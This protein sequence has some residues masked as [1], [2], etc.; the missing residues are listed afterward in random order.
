MLIIAILIILSVLFI[1]KLFLQFRYE[2]SYFGLY[3]V[4]LL[5][6]RN[7]KIAKTSKDVQRALCLRDK[8]VAIEELIAA[9]AW[10]P[11]LSIESV[12][13][14]KWIQLKAN[15]AIFHKHLPTVSELGSKAR[16]EIKTFLN[17]NKGTVLDSKMISLMTLKIFLKWLF[18]DS[19]LLEVNQDML[20]HVY[21]SSLEYRK[22]IAFKGKGCQTRK[23]MVVDI[24]VKL[25]NKSKRYYNIF[26][27]WTQP[28]CFS[29]VLQP[30]IISP[31]I[32]VSDI[33][34]SIEKYASNYNKKD[35][36]S[37]ID[38]CI[39]MEHPFPMLER[40]DA[41]T[42]TQIFINLSEL[43]DA[44]FNYGYGPRACLGRLYAIEF[45]KEFFQPI[46]NLNYENFKPKVNHL[47]SGR[48]ND[49]SNLKESF[50]QVKYFLKKSFSLLKSY[51]FDF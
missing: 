30:F 36:N 33:A 44:R 35:I 37:F 13:G 43:K 18:V 11:I 40:Y 31:M 25:L 24:V 4:T 19:D 41:S 14:K 50:Y 27:D 39:L 32:N 1:L 20:E 45:L 8:G 9:P 23:Q 46:L 48:D 12:N 7:F 38:Y 5:Q 34:V 3:V 21:E 2:F 49:R 15:Y 29:V 47:Y 16:D 42:N 28:E 6:K 17:L 26:P 10:L 22:E 51:F